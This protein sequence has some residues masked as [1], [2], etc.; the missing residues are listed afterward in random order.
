MEF[1]VSDDR[2]TL[3]VDKSIYT[4]DVVHKCFYWYGANYSIEIENFSDTQL[5][6]VLRPLSKSSEEIDYTE[7]T[8][9]IRR[10]LVDF[11]LR[12]TVTKE[13]K[14]IRELIIA[15]AFAYYG[16]SD[17]PSDEIT[18]PVGFDPNKINENDQQ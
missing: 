14:T 4:E 7:I 9:K 10:D 18:D 16:L 5:K 8:N 11:K 6:I 2:I 3:K 15:K 12:D 17:N 13:T 1:E